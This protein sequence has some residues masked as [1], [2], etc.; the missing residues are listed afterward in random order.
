MFRFRQRAEEFAMSLLPSIL[1]IGIAA[2]VLM[3]GW[4][5]LLKR[6]GVA[7]LDYAMLGRWA[8]HLLRGQVHHAGIARAE[9][10]SHER[11][12]GWALHYAVGLLFAAGLLLVVGEGWLQAP[13]PGP[14][15]IFGLVT[16]LLPW[17]VMQPAMGAGFFASRTPTPWRNRLRS[18]GT[19]GVFGVGLY[20]GACLVP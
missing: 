14:A 7:T 17:C 3:D 5:L 15:L 4:T 8:G 2:T 19:H 6:L 16:V 13:T 9:P 12:W 1:L 10:V 20:L 18:L 11:A